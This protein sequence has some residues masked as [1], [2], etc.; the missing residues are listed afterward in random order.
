[1]FKYL[2]NING[3][4]HPTVINEFMGFADSMGADAIRIG[5]LCSLNA[6]GK[7]NGVCDWAK[8]MFLPLDVKED[9][10][11][12]LIKCI[13]I[14]KGA[15]LLADVHPEADLDKLVVGA[16]VGFGE[17]IDYYA[18]YVDVVNE[19]YLFEIIDDSEKEKGRVTGVVI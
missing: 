13:R 2:R 19:G 4:Y 15:V 8:P 16:L 7:L 6:D 12:K 11:E 17:E 1:M 9:D 14:D 10:E 18:I 5:T 3:P